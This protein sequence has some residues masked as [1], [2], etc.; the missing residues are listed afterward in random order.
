MGHWHTY[1]WANKQYT[2]LSVQLYLQASS[3]ANC[4]GH[5]VCNVPVGTYKQSQCC[6][7]E[8]KM[9]EPTPSHTDLFDQMTHSLPIDGVLLA[10]L[11]ASQKLSKCRVQAL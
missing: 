7:E 5:H 2:E 6:Q 10:M 9:K 3:C 4:R 11:E 1:Y 8:H